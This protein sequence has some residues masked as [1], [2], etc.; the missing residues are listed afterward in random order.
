MRLIELSSTRASFKTVRFNRTGLTLIVGKHSKQQAKNLHAT[1]NGV[2]KSLLVALLHFCLGASKNKQFEAHLKGWD[3]TLTFEHAGK[4]HRVTRT[5]G[6]D[7]LQFD[8]K[9]MKLTPYK[10]A[11]TALGV[12][13][14]PADVGGLSFRSLIS[15]FLRPA[16]GSYTS[17]DAAIAQWTPYYRVLYPSFLLG[18]DFHRVVQKHDAKKKLDEQTGLAK[19]YKEDEDLRAFYVGGKSAEV[20]L[21]S[22][23]ERI[24]KLEVDLSEFVVAR[25][26]SEREAAANSLR[27]R[28]VEAR[29]EEAILAVRLSDIELA[30]AT[31]P[32]VTPDRVTRLYTEAKIALP[33]AVSKRLDEVDAF[34]ARLRENRLLRLGQEQTIALAEQQKWQDSRAVLEREL[35]ELLSYLKAHHAL[36]EYTE[37]NRYLSDQTARKRKIE[38]YLALLDKYTNE[39]Q[40]IR[41]E[42]GTATVQTTEYLEGIKAHRDRLMDAFR[43]YAREFY[44]DKPAGLLV[45]NND[46]DDNQIRYD[47]EVRIEH[48]QA[49]GIND[50]RIFCFDLVL[51]ALRQRHGAEFLFH[52]SRLFAAM[53]WHQR[54]TLFRL[55]DRVTRDNGWQYIATVNEDH[56]ESVREAAGADFG[57]LFVEP[58]VLE[59]TDEASGVGKLLGVQV[60]MKYDAE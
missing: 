26:Y 35:D 7:A 17:P 29:N 23:K 51:L 9:E 48:D 5:V 49:D 3:F 8:A 31:R 54:L 21:V 12:F 45:R 36:G 10:D 20:E 56:I 25:D 33:D 41:A 57:R 6:E 58:R 37:N 34:H 27:A 43:T 4:E 44:G 16:R 55:A 52:D 1:Y 18:L 15:F 19:K 42:M 53:D 2:G 40:R 11:L 47:I 60:E 24:A 50:V 46:K 14:I 22:L 38:D 59:L 28:I 39:A 30:L 32:D 13:E